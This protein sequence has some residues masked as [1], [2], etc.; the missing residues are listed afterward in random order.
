MQNP[1]GKPAMLLWMLV[2]AFAAALKGENPP[3][4]GKGHGHGVFVFPSARELYHSQNTL[5]FP[6]LPWDVWRL[7]DQ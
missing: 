7:E 2:I 4:L 5:P 1:L 3:F 6:A